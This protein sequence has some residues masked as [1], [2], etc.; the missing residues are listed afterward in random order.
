MFDS[1]AVYDNKYNKT[2]IKICNNRKNTNFHGNKILEGNKY[3]TGL[4]VIL[5]DFVDKISDNLYV[6]IF[7]AEC[8][9]AVKKIYIYI[10]WIQLMKN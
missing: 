9:Y 8:K 7:L 1:E 10:Y 3:C 2:N 4:S 6:L 5:W